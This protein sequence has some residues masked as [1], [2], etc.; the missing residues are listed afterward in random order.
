MWQGL[1][2]QLERENWAEKPNWWWT[3]FE[4]WRMRNWAEMQMRNRAE[5]RKRWRFGD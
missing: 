1:F 3:C 5:M 4:A 2:E